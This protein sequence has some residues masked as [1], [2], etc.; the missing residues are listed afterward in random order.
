MGNLEFR[1]YLIGIV[2]WILAMKIFLNLHITNLQ[3]LHLKPQLEQELRHL[4]D[5]VLVRLL[6]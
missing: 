2:L 1:D 6:S 4:W 3:S 5:E